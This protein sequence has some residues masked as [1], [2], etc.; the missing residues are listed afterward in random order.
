[1]PIYISK[2]PA[3]FFLYSF[4]HG[5]F[6]LTSSDSPRCM[7]AGGVFLFLDIF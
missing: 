1:M 7:F 6:V 3:K 4:A 2:L 5:I